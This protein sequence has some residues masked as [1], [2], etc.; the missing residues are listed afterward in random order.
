MFPQYIQVQIVK[1]LD[2]LV[3]T[4]EPELWNNAKRSCDLMNAPE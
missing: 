3:T 2:W 4:V 1:S